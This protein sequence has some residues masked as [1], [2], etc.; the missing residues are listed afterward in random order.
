ML[1]PGQEREEKADERRGVQGHAETTISLSP[2]PSLQQGAFVRELNG[3]LA[4]ETGRPGKPKQQVLEEI[5]RLAAS[6][7][8]RTPVDKPQCCEQQQSLSSCPSLL[9]GEQP[10]STF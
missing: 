4:Q 1:Q 6:L 3:H 7:F 10:H 8:Y 9:R 5:S 2:S